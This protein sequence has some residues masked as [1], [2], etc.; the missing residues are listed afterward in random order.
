MAWNTQK[1]H[2]IVGH[3]L[4]DYSDEL[5]ARIA[6]TM[7]QHINVRRSSPSTSA[8][9]GQLAP[10]PPDPPGTR[11]H[12]MRMTGENSVEPL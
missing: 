11:P 6:P 2:P 4:A 10:A 3:S 9:I 12:E 5:I 8:H 1:M 7:H